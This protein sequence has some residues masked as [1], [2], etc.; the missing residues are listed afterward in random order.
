[1]FR[2]D[3]GMGMCLKGGFCDRKTMVLQLFFLMVFMNGFTHALKDVRVTIPQ[4]ARIMD[5]VSLQCRYDLEG[6]PLYTVKWYKG[7]KEFF[8]FI[9]KELP[10]TQVFPLP[11]IDVDLS[12]SNANEVVLRHVQPEV[13]GKYKCEVSSDAP[14]F[15]TLTVSGSLYII[16]TPDEDPTMWVETDFPE[17]GYSIRGNCSTPPSYPTAN[18]TWLINGKKINESSSFHHQDPNA[19]SSFSKRQPLI[20]TSLLETEIDGETFQGGRA[21]VECVASV[22]NLYK[23]SVERVLEEERPR[24]RPSS[25]LGTRD[26]ASA[27]PVANLKLY[28]VLV[29][30]IIFVKLR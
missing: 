21:R 17:I 13:T 16:D 8:R 30:F 5:T 22:F 2:S 7:T 9:P 29:V 20:T 3:T 19:I 25:V 24:P 4:A 6:E 11:G 28:V 23:R 10:N 1:M 18:I 15:Y 12:K 26:S 14:N 27:I